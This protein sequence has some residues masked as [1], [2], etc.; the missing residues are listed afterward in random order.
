M[1]PDG[2]TTEQQLR[3]F[4]AAGQVGAARIFKTGMDQENRNAGNRYL[5]NS[6]RG[7]S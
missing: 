1:R 3:E 2:K 5:R 4:D 6:L 7:S